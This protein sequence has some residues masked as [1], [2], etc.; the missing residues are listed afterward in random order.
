[1]S[2][3]TNYRDYRLTLAAGVPKEITVRGDYWEVVDA[4]DE[5]TL[6]FDQ[7]VRITRG[8]GYGGPADYNTVTIHSATAQTVTV[9]LGLTNGRVPY[10]CRVNARMTLPGLAVPIPDVTVLAGAQALIAAAETLRMKLYIRLASTSPG[11]VRIGDVTVAAGRGHL[12]EPGDGVTI[13]GGMALYA[14]NEAAADT[15]LTLLATKGD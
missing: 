1:V 9:S 10:S 4:A 3:N 15:A 8:Q 12:L 6:E 5:V 13:E 2:L 11:N 7:G 14:F